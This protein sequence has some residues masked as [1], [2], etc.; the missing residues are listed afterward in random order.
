M[1]HKSIPATG[2]RGVAASP[3]T[4]K[5]RRSWLRSDMF[6]AVLVLTPSIIAVALFIYGFI[7]WTFYMS[8]VKWNSQV[9]DFTFVGLA[10]WERLFSDRRFH[11][12]LRNLVYY[13]AGF[14]TQCIVFGFIIAALLDQKIKGEA[15][16]RTIIIFP[17]AVSGIVTGVAWRWLMQPSTGIN[18]LFAKIGLENF[19]P[20]W[21]SHPQYGMWAVSIAAAWQF[22]GYVM[23]L[24]LAGLRGIPNELREAAAI[25]GAGTFAT[26]RHV[27]IPLL[28]PVTFTAIV[29]TGMNS[30]RV[31]DLVSAMSG[32]GP[33]FATDTLAFYMFQSTFGAYRYSL[34]A[35]IGS[36][37]IFLSAFL[38]VPYLMSMRGEVER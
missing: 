33:A 35:A 32:S 6:I 20:T 17:F 21:N 28:M 16:Y 22:T 10:N 3:I 29:L 11:I 38:I 34:G 19:Q 26:Y 30:I 5:R 18:L 37:M 27:I 23:A 9:P 24:Y 4:Q 14:M 31:F 12:D 25:D 1:A 7:G 15:I 13:A 2:E 8:T 36:F